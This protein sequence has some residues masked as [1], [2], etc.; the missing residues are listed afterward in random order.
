[1]SGIAQSRT[2]RA[3][4]VCLMSALKN[5]RAFW[6]VS[7]L[8]ARVFH[9]L[10]PVGSKKVEAKA[11]GGGVNDREELGSKLDPQG[12]L[13][14]TFK[15]RELHPLTMILTQF[16]DLPE[17][18]LP[19]L[20]LSSHVI[21]DEHHHGFSSPNEGRVSIEIAAQ[22]ASQQECLRVGHQT[23]GDAL[24]QKWMENLLLFAQLPC[25]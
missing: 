17:A 4:A 6:V 3:E 25:N 15:N 16:G 1:M 8:G 18:A 14:K 11:I 2:Y 20:G 22:V 19:A 5:E 7:G 21:R 12:W 24:V 13:K 10:L 23:K 9:A